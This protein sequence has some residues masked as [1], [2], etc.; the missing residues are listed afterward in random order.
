MKLMRFSL[1]ITIL[2]LS[3]LGCKDRSNTNVYNPINLTSNA[4]LL[5][6]AVDLYF[7][8]LSYRTIQGWVSVG[9]TM[10]V[11]DYSAL[12]ISKVM[13]ISALYWNPNENSVNAVGHIPV[14]VG[15]KRGKAELCIENLAAQSD[16]QILRDKFATAGI[17][18]DRLVSVKRG[19]VFYQLIGHRDDLREL[20]AITYVIPQTLYESR[21]QAVESSLA[22]VKI[23]N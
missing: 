7:P 2:L 10:D 9:D 8:P 13:Q 11:Q 3:L 6:P 1:F 16:K 21:K 12:G 23:R 19:Y 22:S 17:Y 14:P 4:A 5:N 20:L 18:F 15:Q